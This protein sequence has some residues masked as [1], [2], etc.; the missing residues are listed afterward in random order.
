MLLIVL[1]GTLFWYL[2]RASM[3]TALRVTPPKEE[4]A[5]VMR[6]VSKQKSK[7]KKGRKKQKHS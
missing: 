6:T 3:M 4:Q 2:L 5:T 7:G 1:L